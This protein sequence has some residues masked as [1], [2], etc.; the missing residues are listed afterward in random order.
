M[1]T[2]VPLRGTIVPLDREGT[3]NPV[4]PPFFPTIWPKTW[5]VG[6]AQGR[7]KSHLRSGVFADRELSQNLGRGGD[8]KIGKILAKIGEFV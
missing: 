3:R 8:P 5:S 2:M 6:S 1:G 4:S 7:A